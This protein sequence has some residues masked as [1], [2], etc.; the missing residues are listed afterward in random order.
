MLKTK[1]KCIVVVQKSVIVY[2]NIAFCENFLNSVCLAKV[3]AQTTRAWERKGVTWAQGTRLVKSTKNPDS[4]IANTSAFA[5]PVRL[6]R[7][8]Y[9]ATATIVVRG[10]APKPFL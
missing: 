5:G 2:I 3:H 1:T 10:T 7:F 8:R 9:L 6:A 4:V